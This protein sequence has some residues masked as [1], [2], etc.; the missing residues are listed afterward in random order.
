SGYELSEPD[1][2]RTR[3]PLEDLRLGAQR[4]RL[5]SATLWC[6]A[7]A[8]AAFCID[9]VTLNQPITAAERHVGR[10][11]VWGSVRVSEGPFAFVGILDELFLSLD[12]LYIIP[13]IKSRICRRFL[14]FV[15]DNTHRA[16]GGEVAIWCGCLRTTV[17]RA[18]IGVSDDRVLDGRI[19]VAHIRV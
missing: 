5:P 11:T 2:P 9:P 3:D 6:A 19:A 14:D 10:G 17:V 12:P 4:L 16:V 18:P 15:S 8:V 1:E 7:R 13:R